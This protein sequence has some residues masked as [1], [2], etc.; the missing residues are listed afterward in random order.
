MA[1][2]GPKRV[3][4]MTFSLIALGDAISTNERIFNIA[5]LAVMC[6][7]LLHGL[8]DTPGA[9]WIARRAEGLESAESRAADAASSA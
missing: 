1:C 2:F 7:I 3:A 4:T 6:S 5:A 8:S 9:N